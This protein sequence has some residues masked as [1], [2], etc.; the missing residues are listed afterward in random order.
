MILPL[1]EGVLV[2]ETDT[3]DLW[4]HVDTDGD[5]VADK[6]ELWY[7]G[8]K[9]GGNLEHQ[10]SGLIWSQDNWIYASYNS[11]RLRFTG[12]GRAPL[13]EPTPGNGGQWGLTQDDYGKPW[14]V[15]A[16]GEIGPLNFQVPIVY[17]GFGVKHQVAP[18]YAEVWPAIGLADVQG[19]PPRFRPGDKTLNHFTATCGPDLYRGDRLPPDLRGDLLFGEPVGRLIR[20]TKV[21]VKDGLTYLR[22]AYE[23]TE[24]IRSTDPNFRPINIVTG[25]DGTLSIVD[26]YRGIIQGWCCRC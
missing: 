5:G 4:Y 17:G 15:N 3:D 16:G 7:A 24:F 9:R 25:P 14:F 18:G 2:N 10:A 23:K 19:G 11:Y 22:N 26:M 13:K 21:E 12:L 6:K 20:R 1:A 8:G